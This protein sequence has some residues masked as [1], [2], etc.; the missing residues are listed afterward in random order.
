MVCILLGT[1]FEESEA[2]VPTDLLRRAGVEV[3][4]TALSGGEVTSSHNITV[5]ADKPLDQIDPAEVDLIFVPG[6]LGGVDAIQNCP[7]A[8]KLIQAVYDKGGYVTAICAGPTVLAGM[9]LLQ[10][11]QAVCFPGMEDQ[12]TGAVARKGT[13]VVVDGRLVTAEAAGSAFTFG[14]KLVELLKGRE[15]ARQVC[16]SVHYHGDF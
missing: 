8:L 9:G 16:N 7:A 6:G 13:P 4:L 3:C 15:A 14:L 5:N 11:R 12:L 10:G 1:G 2:L